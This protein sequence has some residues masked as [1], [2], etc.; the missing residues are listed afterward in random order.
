MLTDADCRNA[1]CPPELKRR[2]LTDSGGLC[3]EVSPAGSKRW[4]WKFYPDGKE[5]RL[6]LGS[7]GTGK[8]ELTLK[9]ARLARNDA[10]RLRQAGTNPVQQRKAEK[11][12]SATSNAI[13]FEA[14]AREFYSTKAT[15]D[16]WGDSHAAQWLRSLEKDLFHWIGSLPLADIKAPMRARH[17]APS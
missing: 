15:K 4:F 3:L 5:S 2:R 9:A 13:T 7:Y 16:G 10:R 11:I 8:D 14:V 17:A 12:A 6:A 1:S